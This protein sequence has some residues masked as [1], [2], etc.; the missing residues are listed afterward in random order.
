MNPLLMLGAQAQDRISIFGIVEGNALHRTREGIHVNKYTRRLDRNGSGL[1][2]GFVARLSFCPAQDD[3]LLGEGL[4]AAPPR[5]D[6]AETR[7]QVSMIPNPA[8][9][10]N[11]L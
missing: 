4:R 10:D 1:L 11:R 5:A 2:S 7:L 9:N 8:V 3:F 6:P